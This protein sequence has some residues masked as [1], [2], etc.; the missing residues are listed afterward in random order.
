[1]DVSVGVAE[2]SLAGAQGVVAV[3]F[4]A[5]KSLVWVRGSLVVHLLARCRHTRQ[6]L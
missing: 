2:P 6:R 4:V 1:M 3:G 5:E